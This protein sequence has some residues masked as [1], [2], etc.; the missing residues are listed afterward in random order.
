MDYRGYVIAPLL[1]S[2]QPVYTITDARLDEYVDCASSHLEAE[3]IID[4][5]LDAK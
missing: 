3:R 5:W 4:S 1:E 2:P